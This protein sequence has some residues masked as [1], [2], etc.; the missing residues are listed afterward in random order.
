M[1]APDE[2]GG[3]PDAS[4]LQVDFMFFGTG[5]G[6]G[7]YGTSGAAVFGG[8]GVAIRAEG[9]QEGVRG[10]FHGDEILEFSC[11]TRTGCRCL[12]G[13]SFENIWCRDKSFQKFGV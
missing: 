2:G 4:A 6:T 9:G 13:L 12:C 8:L 7:A 10:V 3:V 1:C 5:E 11:H